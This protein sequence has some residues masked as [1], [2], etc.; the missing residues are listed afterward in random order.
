MSERT[1]YEPGTPCWIDL[2]T[3]DQD[4]AADFYGGLFGWGVEEDENAEQTGGYRVATL[5]GKAVGGVMKLMQE[6]Q[7]PAWMTYV[8]VEDADATVASAAEAGGEVIVEPMTVLDYGRMAILK[9]TTG[10]VFGIWQPGT[11][12][13]AQVVNENGAFC[14]SEINTRDPDAAEAFYEDVF[15]WSF[16]DREFEGPGTYTIVSVGDN[17]FGGLMDMR[18]RVPDEVPANWLVYFAVEDADATVE[19]ARR[20]GGAV[21]FGPA[22]IAEVG[23]IAVLQDPFGAS[24]AVIQ[25]DP[26][27]GTAG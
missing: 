5:D 13:G 12:V 26:R 27:M 4:A 6:G 16:E 20:R 17:G 25:P 9:D 24:F 22:D 1:S 14:W 18:G 19:E 15:G 11:N 3:P 21:P 7:P 2:A 23:R 8:S 10:A